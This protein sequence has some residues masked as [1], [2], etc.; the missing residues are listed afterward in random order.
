MIHI[1][2]IQMAIMKTSIQLTKKN[3]EA[4]IE[5]KEGYH[6]EISQYSIVELICEENN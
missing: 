5:V 3:E 1:I 4:V 6:I 2:K